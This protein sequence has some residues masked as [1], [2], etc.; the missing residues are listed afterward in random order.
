MR[1]SAGPYTLGRNGPLSCSTS[2]RHSKGPPPS[3]ILL[4]RLRTRTKTRVGRGSRPG[5]GGSGGRRHTYNGPERP[6]VS[7]GFVE[8]GGG[9]NR[10]GQRS[11]DQADSGTGGWRR[12]EN[13]VR[14]GVSEVGVPRVARQLLSKRYIP[15]HDPRSSLSPTY[16]RITN[17]SVL[18]VGTSPG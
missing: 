1:G 10:N 14:D 15:Y 12:V 6:D 13:G 9:R 16:L 8:S 3:F 17:P 4:R 5:L 7:T 11:E 18:C 2:P